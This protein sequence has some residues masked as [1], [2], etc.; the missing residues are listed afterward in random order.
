MLGGNDFSYQV[1]IDA[2][3]ILSRSSL[4][5]FWKSHPD[6]EEALKTWYYEAS[7]ADWQ[8]PA[9]V[10]TAHRNASSVGWV[11]TRKPNQILAIVGFP[12]S[13]Q[14]NL[15][16]YFR[17]KIDMIGWIGTKLASTS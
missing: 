16:S 12:L 1:I 3:R 4:R 11:D 2:M 14:P 7:H 17:Y 13:L 8:S 6:A 9:D 10:K 15:H 5:D